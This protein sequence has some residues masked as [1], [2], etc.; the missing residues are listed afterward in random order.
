MPEMPAYW[1][2]CDD[3]L[4]V[5]WRKREQHKLGNAIKHAFLY[6]P[7][8][9]ISDSMVV[10]N[11]NLKALMCQSRFVQECVRQRLLRIAARSSGSKHAY[12]GD[13]RDKLLKDKR[14][15]SKKQFPQ[16]EFLDDRAFE[17][18]DSHCTFQ[19]YSLDDIS[20][21]FT[22]QVA[23][24][25]QT[26]LAHETLGMEVVNAVATFI[27]T[28]KASN[29]G[30][31]GLGH[32]WYHEHIGQFLNDELGPD[33]WQQV[34]RGIRKFAQAVHMT[35]LPDLLETN[36]V[37]HKQHRSTVDVWRD[38]RRHRHT[39]LGEKLKI[40]NR[41]DLTT[42]VRALE[43]LTFNDL[44]KLR[45]TDE[46]QWY[47]KTRHE[48]SEFGDVDDLLTS[49]LAWRRRIENYIVDKMGTLGSKAATHGTLQFGILRIAGRSKEWLTQKAIDYVDP[50]GANLIGLVRQ[51][52]QP[53]P[54]VNPKN[55]G[56]IQARLEEHQIEEAKRVMAKLERRQRRGRV[57]SL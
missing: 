22:K 28:V 27:E 3:R 7:Q 4:P 36:A 16:R 40:T 55:P 19:K 1:L 53:P 57:K 29:K 18:L 33:I 6:E 46:W 24:I 26:E 48:F 30:M 41:F 50:S 34:R 21:R 15:P 45:N 2:A 56:R 8:L 43:L 23:S 14:A 42:Y 10:T 32:F 51:L 38:R 31:I 52:V 25:F 13:V 12:L 39:A 17:F 54:E 47:R 5:A 35:G 20:I 9:L 44:M 49:H 37:Y 11:R